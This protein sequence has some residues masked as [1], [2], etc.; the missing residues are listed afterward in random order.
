MNFWPRA[1]VVASAAALGWALQIANGF[2]DARA[3]AWLTVA[4]VLAIV[5]P[6]VWRAERSFAAFTPRG[7]LGEGWLRSLTVI[8]V[9]WQIVSLLTTPPGMYLDERANIGLFNAGLIAEAAVISIGVAGIGKL[10]R[11]W[12]PALLALHIAL[13]GWMLRSSPSPRIDVVTVHGAAFEALLQGRSPYDI[14]FEN[15]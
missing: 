1:C 9:A 8:A 13:G 12:F 11:V 10:A 6:V 3:I 4:L 7:R 15:I 5:A 2:Y 14:S